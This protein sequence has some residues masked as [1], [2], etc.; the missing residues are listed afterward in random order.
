M[1]RD[2]PVPIHR[3]VEAGE[4]LEKHMPNPPLPEPQRWT[5]GLSEDGRS[6]I[7]FENDKDAVW[8]GLR[9]S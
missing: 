8:F 1:S 7:R 5:I 6:G 3:L 2:F 9:W 4:W